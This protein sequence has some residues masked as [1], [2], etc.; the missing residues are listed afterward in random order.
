MMSWMSGSSSTSHRSDFGTL[1]IP[2]PTTAVFE[3]LARKVREVSVDAQA[4]HPPKVSKPLRKV[5]HPTEGDAS[6]RTAILRL[7]DTLDRNATQPYLPVM[8][9]TKAELAAHPAIPSNA[10]RPP[11]AESVGVVVQTPIVKESRFVSS[12]SP[13]HVSSM[14]GKVL[15]AMENQSNAYLKRGEFPKARSVL[16]E[17]RKHRDPGQPWTQPEALDRSVFFSIEHQWAQLL[18]KE[19]EFEQAKKAFTSLHDQLS[20]E[21]LANWEAGMWL[22]RTYD[23][24][25]EYKQADEVLRGLRKT[26]TMSSLY[27]GKYSKEEGHEVHHMLILTESV[28]SLV[29]AHQGLFQSALD[30]SNK[31]TKHPAIKELEFEA[32]RGKRISTPTAESPEEIRGNE[33]T[34]H[35]Q[36][37]EEGKTEAI[38]QGR[39]VAKSHAISSSTNRCNEKEKDRAE[40]LREIQSMRSQVLWLA[41]R[42]SVALDL[43]RGVVQDFQE[44]LGPKHILTLENRTLQ[45]EMLLAAGKIKDAEHSCQETL[46]EL[47]A[48]HGRYH[49]STLRAYECK[50]SILCA[51]GRLTEARNLA[52]ALVSWNT[53][54]LGA[55]HIR[56]IL[57]EKELAMVYC[58]RGDFEDA[59]ALQTVI[60]KAIVAFGPT[61]LSTL[62]LQADLATVLCVRGHV[63]AAIS[64]AYATLQGLSRSGLSSV[65]ELGFDL[66]M[67]EVIGTPIRKLGEDVLLLLK[68]ERFSKFR[69]QPYTQCLLQVLQCLGKCE[70]ERTCGDLALSAELLK[71]IYTTRK[72]SLLFPELDMDTLSCAYQLAVILRR[73]DQAK[74]ALGYLDEALI[75]RAELLGRN[76]QQTLLTRFEHNLVRFYLCENFTIKEQ[77]INI[78]EQQITIKEEQ[79]RMVYQVAELL[80]EAHT[81]TIAMRNEISAMLQEMGYLEQAEQEIFD[82]LHQQLTSASYSAS[83]ASNSVASKVSATA[84]EVFLMLEEM[85]K[86]N[87]W[88]T[89]VAQSR[90]LSNIERV[91]DIEWEWGNYLRALT[92]QEA[93]AD[94]VRVWELDPGSSLNARY[95]L[96]DMYQT[97]AVNVGDSDSQLLFYKKAMGAYDIVLN[98]LSGGNTP[99]RQLLLATQTNYGSIYFHLGD[100]KAALKLQQKVLE[101]V[102]SD[103][104][105]ANT[106]THV[107][108]ICKI[109]LTQKAM[110]NVSEAWDILRQ[111]LQMDPLNGNLLAIE[112]EWELESRVR[113]KAPWRHVVSSRQRDSVMSKGSKG[114][115]QAF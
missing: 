43:N 89:R 65:S 21:S 6:S 87:D 48:Q 85:K 28:L 93:Y 66:A 96:G 1:G 100:F 33:I 64:Q 51:Q 103:N 10:Q 74:E 54:K 32:E 14:N 38:D 110:D 79:Q 40:F 30:I 73:N 67:T 92:A 16:E 113:A 2:P 20:R 105:L 36:G 62:Q 61:H 47:Y 5:L 23:A 76:Q 94:L 91:A 41:G 88:Q 49:P 82:A 80:G 8:L 50:V 90:V 18:F 15:S 13:I 44:L 56:T 95:D 106:S 3:E 81:D 55:K 112:K 101:T 115:I 27:G 25:G 63:S 19:G 68:E 12:V 24:T 52:R 46:I 75:G 83:H 11:I 102:T 111:A 98:E 109:A 78:K 70:S 4:H 71:K 107:E 45:S 77:Q 72:E 39:E 37:M 35:S 58:A 34:L 42:R 84:D 114:N 104:E 60:E 69:E 7:P 53:T 99:D 59:M 22:G 97:Y 9:D 17:I 26:I 57:A 108:S 31:V 29:M 86:D